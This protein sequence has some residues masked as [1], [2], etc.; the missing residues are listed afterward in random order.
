MPCASLQPNSLHRGRFRAYLG[1]ALPSAKSV[2]Q[3]LA[4]TVDLVVTRMGA[5][6]GADPKMSV[7][8][9]TGLAV[10]ASASVRHSGGSG[11]LLE[12]QAQVAALE[13]LAEAARGG[14][15][16]LVVIEGGA[17]IGKTR[18]L[19]EARAMAGSAGMR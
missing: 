1:K 12:R 15:G 14:A 2:S 7:E 13:S 19:G 16:G 6:H 10:M 5:S 18:L 8:V 9:S 3:R 11:L 4:G 17:G